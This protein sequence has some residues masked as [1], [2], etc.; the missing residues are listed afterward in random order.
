MFFGFVWGSDYL[1]VSIYLNKLDDGWPES[2]ERC[3]E[4]CK[5]EDGIA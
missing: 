4:I 3:S 5:S 1:I 2:E